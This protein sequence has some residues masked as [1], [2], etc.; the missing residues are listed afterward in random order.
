[1]SQNGD[2]AANGTGWP[3]VVLLVEL[4]A[5]MIAL[6]L[7][8]TPSKTGSTWSPANVFWAEPSYPQE[9]AVSFVVVNIL[10]VVFALAVWIASRLGASD[11]R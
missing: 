1:M 4:V 3:T 5:F 6:V 8:I 10:I 7:P 2:R 9:V 11:V